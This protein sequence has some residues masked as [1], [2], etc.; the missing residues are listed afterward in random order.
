MV[1]TQGES[2]VEWKDHQVIPQEKTG[3]G[4]KWKWITTV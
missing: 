4:A 3:V 2:G 1:E